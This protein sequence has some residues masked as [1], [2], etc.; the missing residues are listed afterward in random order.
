MGLQ[1]AGEQEDTDKALIEAIEALTA[2]LTEGQSPSPSFD[3]GNPAQAFV[4]DAG[5][6]ILKPISKVSA[7]DIALLSGIDRAK[8]ALVENS[9][10]FAAGFSA[11]NALLWGARGMGKSTLVKSA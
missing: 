4:F 2:A 8:N 1:V 11:N 7:P 10:R 6:A 3:A 9:R 5:A